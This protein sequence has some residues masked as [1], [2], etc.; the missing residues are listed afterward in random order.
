MDGGS[1]RER[2]AEMWG[3]GVNSQ[4]ESHMLERSPGESKCPLCLGLPANA[5]LNEGGDGGEVNHEGEPHHG[6]ALTPC[7]VK[8][9]GWPGRGEVELILAVSSFHPPRFVFGSQS[10]LFLITGSTYCCYSFTK[11]KFD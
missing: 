3:L 1:R 8:S 7:W 10:L 2:N 4:T 6:R 5:D 11:A 9:T